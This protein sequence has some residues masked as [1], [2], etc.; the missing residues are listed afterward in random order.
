MFISSLS[1]TDNLAFT[2]LCCVAQQ[3]HTS[4]TWLSV[5]DIHFDR[6]YEAALLAP[7]D[8]TVWCSVQTF[9]NYLDC[10]QE[11][12]VNRQFVTL[13]HIQNAFPDVLT[14]E[15]MAPLFAM[16]GASLSLPQVT[17]YIM[18]RK[19][20]V[21]EGANYLASKLLADT[22]YSITRDINLIDILD[23]I[24]EERYVPMP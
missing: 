9:A 7:E 12:F 5:N 19:M 18:Y 10:V 11:Q 20:G 17:A 8:L 4:L 6:K 3:E 22:H 15:L 21:V 13:R 24:P 1:T 2:A 16:E 14:S 23:P